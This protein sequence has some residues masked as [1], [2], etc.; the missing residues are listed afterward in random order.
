MSKRKY[1][2]GAQKLQEQ[3]RKKQ[4]IAKLQK[5]SSIFLPNRPD[6]AAI[7]NA[8]DAVSTGTNVMDAPVSAGTN[9]EANVRLTAVGMVQADHTDNAED[10]DQSTSCA[11]P[12]QQVDEETE[13]DDTRPNQE[14]THTEKYEQYPS[15]RAN[16]PVDLTDS[17]VKRTILDLGSCKPEGPFPRDKNGR[18]FSTEYYCKRSKLGCRV[19]RKWLCYSPKMDRVYCEPCWLFSD[20]RCP[21]HQLSWTVGINDWQGL[22]GKIKKH[23]SLRAHLVACVVFDTWK[24]DL[25]VDAQLDS[26]YKRQVH[27]WTQVLTRVTD[28]TLTLA[29]CNLAFRGHREQVGELNNGNFLSVIELLA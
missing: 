1:P 2:S 14:A 16:F 7:T 5:I 13:P 18:C 9:I 15:D 6:A 25:T 26:E 3:Q 27:F 19:P 11:P 12:E 17:T 20:R 23:E 4:N 22:S 10:P 28:I 21:S 29:S 8:G 24:N